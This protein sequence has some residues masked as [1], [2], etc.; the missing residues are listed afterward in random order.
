VVVEKFAKSGG[1]AWVDVAVLAVLSPTGMVSP[2]VLEGAM[3]GVAV[4]SPAGAWDQWEGGLSSLL[5]A[6]VEFARPG[7]RQF[8]G[9]VKGLLR[10]GRGKTV[11]SSQ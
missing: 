8:L 7:A 6:D 11:V 5:K 3:A 4:V 1:N 2:V 10:E 9:M